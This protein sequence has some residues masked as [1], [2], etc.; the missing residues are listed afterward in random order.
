MSELSSWVVR[1]YRPVALAC[2]VAAFALSSALSLNKNGGVSFWLM[3][4]AAAVLTAGAVGLP[5]FAERAASMRA[6]DAQDSAEDAKQQMRLVVGRVLTPLAYL[7][8]EITDAQPRSAA[9]GR[10]QGQ[11]MQVVLA[12]ATELVDATDARACFFR[13]ADGR[14]RQRRMEL[15]GYYGRAQPATWVLTSG[16]PLGDSALEILDDDMTA[17]FPDLTKEAP[18]GWDDDEH[19][20]RALVVVPIATEQRQF[21]LMTVDTLR[22]CGLTEQDAE[23]VQLLGELLSAGF[24]R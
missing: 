2:A 7:L 5:M 18:P 6:G 3:L 11:A 20:H 4:A 9:V 24:N 13:L 23:V 1:N 19:R 21:G 12:A 15:A 14:N 10:L 22:T 17:F 8:G 16:T